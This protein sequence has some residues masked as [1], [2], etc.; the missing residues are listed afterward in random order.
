MIRLFCVSLLYPV[1]YNSVSCRSQYKLPD[2]IL[3]TSVNKDV[4]ECHCINEYKLLFLVQHDLIIYIL[5]CRVT[6]ERKKNPDR[7]LSCIMAVSCMKGAELPI[8]HMKCYTQLTNSNL[9]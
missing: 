2:A 1:I 3:V 9:T 7:H 8:K 5:A 6:F 4:K